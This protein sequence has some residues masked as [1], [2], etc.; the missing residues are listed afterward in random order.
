MTE[1]R[2]GAE[3]ASRMRLASWGTSGGL[4]IVFMSCVLILSDGIDAYKV[5]L[6]ILKLPLRNQAIPAVALTE[7]VYLAEKGRTETKAEVI[8]RIVENAL[9]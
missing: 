1:Y 2:S 8:F 7:A 3:M 5:I 9:N 4:S 6:P